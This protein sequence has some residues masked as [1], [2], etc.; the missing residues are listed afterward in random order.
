[1]PDGDMPRYIGFDAH[2][3]Y[4]YVVELRE[5]G[6]RL[7]YRVALPDGLPA[8]K[9]RLDADCQLVLEASTN[10][11]RLAD[12]LAP[13]VGRLV[14]GDPAQTRGAI[15]R[16]AT[17]DRNAAEALARLLAS[18]FVRP[19]WVPPQEIRSLRNLV[20]LRVRLARLRV[21]SV[22]RIR[23]MLRQELVPGKPAL[24][25]ENVRALIGSDPTLQAYCGSLFA[26]RDMVAKECGQVDAILHAWCRGSE[27]ARLLLS[28]PGIGPL[29]A[30]CLVA[31]VGDVKRFSSARKLCSYAGLVPRVHASGQS[32]R[33]GSITR[34]GRR[35]LRW[36]MGIAAMSATRVDSSL[37]EFKASLCQRRPKGVAMVA[38]ARK[39]LTV[40]WRVWT[41]REPYATEDGRYAT[42]L[43]R[44]DR[45]ST[46]DQ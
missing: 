8:F 20:E 28:V 30:A 2:K 7:N 38:C 34:A 42:K 45:G 1:M 21:A 17:T 27:D 44:L 15:S 25:E 26:V 4:A 12:E 24:V 37:S 36:A 23:A 22:N 39:L 33:S 46:G 11:F 13:H 32:Y 14:V 10:T 18:D 6:K 40:V 43:A 29:V 19:V 35:T 31:Q 41:T 9:Q 16:P 5:D 3:S